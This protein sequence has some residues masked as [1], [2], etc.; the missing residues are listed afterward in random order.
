MPNKLA[1]H[2]LV[3]I[4]HNNLNSDETG[5]PKHY[6]VG[7]T[8]RSYLSSQSIKRGCR[9]DYQKDV[10]LSDIETTDIRSG[11]HSLKIF[12]RAKE[13]NPDLDEKVARKI[14]TEAVERLT[15]STATENDTVLD[16]EK[17]KQKTQD[18]PDGE[19]KEKTSL[20]GA[21]LSYEEM[22]CIAHHVA[23]GNDK[24]KQSDVFQRG[25]TGALFIAGFG[26]MFAAASQYDI[27]AALSVSEGFTTHHAHITTDFFTAVD[28]YLDGGAL[29]MGTN[30]F[31]SGMYYQ[32]LTI[33]K[34]QLK[35]TWTGFDSDSAESQLRNFVRALLTGKPS[36]KK[37]STRGACH[38]SMV[39]ISEF[40]ES[41]G[42][43]FSS[44]VS[45][46]ESG[47]FVLPSL[48]Q[49]AKTEM[50]NRRFA[51]PDEYGDVLSVAGTCS[52]LGE[53][54]S[55][56]DGITVHESRRGIV[57]DVVQWILA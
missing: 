33:D 21:Y 50:E 2:I 9:T 41:P 53:I 43:S 42:H 6:F 47:S 32:L 54:F 25:R 26:R 37:N 23:R 28:D 12:N 20:R 38:P 8:T 7:N 35:A 11:A 14:L 57:D 19:R 5:T 55:D 10:P 1:I 24:L 49:F 36:G 30:M 44:A 34:D 27:D 46:D 39:F 22:E 17:L 15:K 51:E 56:F 18:D 45:C 40:K 48:R 3:E 13:I 29:H 4:P 16:H 52:E 31:T